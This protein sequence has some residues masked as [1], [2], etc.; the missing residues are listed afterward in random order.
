VITPPK[1]VITK[2]EKVS[3]N[4]VFARLSRDGLLLLTTAQQIARS[5][6]LTPL[7]VRI[8]IC[9]GLSSRAFKRRVIAVDYSGRER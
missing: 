3:A 2:A 7:I 1:G 6:D 9:A 8:S 4:M 5:P